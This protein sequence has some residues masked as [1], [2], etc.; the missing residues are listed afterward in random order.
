MLRQG[1]LPACADKCTMGA[2]YF[3]DEY[4]DVVINSKGETIQ[5]STLTKR[6]ASFRLMEELGTEP[7]VYY[8]PPKDRKYDS[9]DEKRAKQ[10]AEAMS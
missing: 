6:G 5:F 10:A 9:P 4:E 1:K 3:G 7:R 2:V 8:L